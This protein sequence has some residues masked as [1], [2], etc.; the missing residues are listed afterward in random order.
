MAFRKII[1]T[2]SFPF[3]EFQTVLNQFFRILIAPEITLNASRRIFNEQRMLKSPYL[4][5]GQFGKNDHPCYLSKDCF[6]LNDPLIYF[7]SGR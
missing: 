1:L 3:D 5:I 4:R 2:N 6:F 7:L